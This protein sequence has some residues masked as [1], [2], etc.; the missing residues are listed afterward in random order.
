[1][2]NL[3]VIHPFI[4]NI[5]QFITVLFIF[6]FVIAIT[7]ITTRWIANFQ[8]QRSAGRNIEAVEA[9]RLTNN[10]FIQIVRVGNEYLVI[11]VCKDTVTMLTKL[12]ETQLNLLENT[13]VESF[14]SFQQILEKVKNLRQKNKGDKDV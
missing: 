4:E 7:Y 3:L 11:A 5:I 12:D 6:V 13:P 9:F 1:M 8:K 14:E 2:I 10:K